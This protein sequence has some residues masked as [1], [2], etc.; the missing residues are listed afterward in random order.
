MEFCRD[1]ILQLEVPGNSISAANDNP[2]ISELTKVRVSM[3]DDDLRLFESERSEIV[4]FLGNQILYENEVSY[5]PYNWEWRPKHLLPGQYYL[6]AF[7]VGFNEHFG[8]SML[9]VVKTE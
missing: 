3:N 7:V 9:K 2:Q 5:Y 1:A 4:F 6:T 8:M